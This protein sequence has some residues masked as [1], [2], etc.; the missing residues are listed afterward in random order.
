MGLIQGAHGGPHRAS[1]RGRD[2][3]AIH[4][5]GDRRNEI[6]VILGKKGAGKSTVAR[7]LILDKPR[8]IIIDPMWEHAR[9]GVTVDDFDAMVRYIRPLRH[10]RY[11]VVLRTLDDDDRD[12]ALALV[13][14]GKPTDPPLPNCTLLVDEIDRM[15]SAHSIPAPLH[16]IVNYGRHFSVSLIA[17]A[18][19]PRAMHRDITAMA[20]RIIVG[21]M[22]EPADLEYLA[23][24]IGESL[25]E[26]ASGLAPR[27]FLVWPDDLENSNNERHDESEKP[28]AVAV[29]AG[30]GQ[31]A[32]A[33]AEFP[34]GVS[35]GET[36]G[37]S[38]DEANAE[39]VRSEGSSDGARLGA[40]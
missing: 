12:R 37:H 20:D 26:R 21:E 25:A 18:R 7:S 10:G 1:S 16:R 23:E 30:A 8:R 38:S 3:S 6:T 31:A 34:A 36:E 11:A 17:L 19:R 5:S 22:Q 29:S 14:E 39:N 28:A 40:H 33:P 35:G 27:E 9:L 15:C 32:R 4:G 24:F 13:T 2:A